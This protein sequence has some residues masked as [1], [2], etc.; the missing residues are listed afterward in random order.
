MGS[1]AGAFTGLASETSSRAMMTGMGGIEAESGSETDERLPGTGI[2]GERLV[3]IVFFGVWPV[4]AALALAGTFSGLMWSVPW[5]SALYSVPVVTWM[6]GGIWWWVRGPQASWQRA[7]RGFAQA[8]VAAWLIIDAV[9]LSGLFGNLLL[10]DGWVPGTAG[11]GGIGGFYLLGF[12]L[13]VVTVV[14]GPAVA[15]VWALLSW[16][17]WCERA[18]TAAIAAW[19]AVAGLF[20]LTISA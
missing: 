15:L 12:S 5:L 17:R 10:S 3:A 9:S 18:A 7:V 14:P 19:T 6:A 13:G 8:H 20:V 11:F 16:L 2:G 4:G 1:V